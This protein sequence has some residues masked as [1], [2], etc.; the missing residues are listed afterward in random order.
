[1]PSAQSLQIQVFGLSAF[2]N[3]ETA[4]Y[5]LAVVALA[6]IVCLSLRRR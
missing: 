4:I 1:M 3:G 5:S 2:A 6:F